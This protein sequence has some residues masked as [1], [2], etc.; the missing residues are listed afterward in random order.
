MSGSRDGARVRS[1]F[2]SVRDV[3]LFV[4]GAA[5]GAWTVTHPPIEP[6]ALAAAV[7]LCVAPAAMLPGRRG[8][9]EGQ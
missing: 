1:G 2:E 3:A 4:L 7:G 8:G 9:G 5:L 6:I